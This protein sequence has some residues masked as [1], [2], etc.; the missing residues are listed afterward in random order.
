MMIKLD[1]GSSI[2]DTSIF[3][4]R[5]PYRGSAQDEEFW[6][7]GEILTS[8]AWE[9][10]KMGWYSSKIKHGNG[11]SPKKEGCWWWETYLGGGTI[12]YSLF[13]PPIHAEIQYFTRVSSFCF[14]GKR[15]VEAAHFRLWVQN[16]PNSFRQKLYRGNTMS[17]KTS[18]AFL[19]FPSVFARRPYHYFPSGKDVVQRSRFWRVLSSF[20]VHQ[21]QRMHENACLAIILCIYNYIYIHLYSYIYI[22]YIHSTHVLSTLHVKY[23]QSFPKTAPEVGKHVNSLF[24]AKAKQFLWRKPEDP[25]WYPDGCWIWEDS[26]VVRWV[27][28][29]NLTHTH[30]IPRE[31][32]GQIPL[33]SPEMD[34]MNIG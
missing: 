13:E 4:I 22:H 27:S 29:G 25:A 8:Q 5:N 9:I 16:G 23:L 20:F 32:I 11:R 15:I 14:F 12:E 24:Q 21:S 31:K 33:S 19:F 2:S 1:M 10:L 30:M 17:G 34:A 28:I 18:Q 3:C 26:P 7:A 6:P